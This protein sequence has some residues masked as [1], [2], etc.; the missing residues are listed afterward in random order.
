MNVQIFTELKIL[1]LTDACW[2]S[3]LAFAFHK[4]ILRSCQMEITFTNILS[5]AKAQQ[6]Q[7]LIQIESRVSMKIAT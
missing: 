4:E 5:Y 1:L 3:M 7:I 2:G 6:S